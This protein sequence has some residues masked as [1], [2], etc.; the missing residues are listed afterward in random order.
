MLIIMPIFFFCFFSLSVQQQ[1]V[2][3]SLESL[4]TLFSY[5]ENISRQTHHKHGLTE[6]LAAE[7][8]KDYETFKI[9]IYLKVACKHK[10]AIIF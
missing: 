8:R 4:E 5:N 10:H 7:R 2:N 1:T 6:P 3:V 9:N